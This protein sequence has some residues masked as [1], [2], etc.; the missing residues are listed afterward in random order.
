MRVMCRLPNSESDLCFNVMVTRKRRGAPSPLW[1]GLGRG[2]PGLEG[3]EY[4]F[5]R[6]AQRH[7]NAVLSTR[8]ASRRDER[9]EWPDQPDGIGFRR[10]LE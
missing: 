7:V 2:E 3:D 9:K 1:G 4:L 6:R 10:D 5:R 8:P